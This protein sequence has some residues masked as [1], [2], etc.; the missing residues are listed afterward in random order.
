MRALRLTDYHES[1]PS[2]TKPQ[3]A[4][5]ADAAPAAVAAPVVPVDASSANTTSPKA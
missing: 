5:A 2:R 4:S 1:Y 3:P